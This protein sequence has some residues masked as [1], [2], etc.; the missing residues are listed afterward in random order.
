MKNAKWIGVKSVTNVKNKSGFAE[1]S[2]P[3][4]INP[5]MGLLLKFKPPNDVELLIALSYL[6]YKVIYTARLITSKTHAFKKKK[7]QNKSTQTI[8]QHLNFD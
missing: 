4:T 3:S 7:T 1:L 6:G 5:S 8:Q 2:E